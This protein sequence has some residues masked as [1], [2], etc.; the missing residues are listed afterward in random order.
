[1][2]SNNGIIQ[3]HYIFELKRQPTFY[4]CV[5]VAPIFLISTLSIL[6]IFTP[7][8]TEGVRSEKVSLGLGSLMATT[9]L[10][11][12]VA[13]AMPKSNSLPLLGILV[14]YNSFLYHF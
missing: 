2:N 5:I 7:G 4:L 3:V 11:G 8:T 13:G 1:M 10:L 9:V 6:G 14:Y 12:I